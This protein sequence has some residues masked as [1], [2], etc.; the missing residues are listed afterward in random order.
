[1]EPVD[2][3]PIGGLRLFLRFLGLEQKKVAIE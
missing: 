3:A 1:M 2:P